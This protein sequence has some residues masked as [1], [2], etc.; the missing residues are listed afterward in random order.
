MKGTDLKAL[1]DRLRLARK[2][3]GFEEAKDA[4]ASLGVNRFTYA[5]HENGTRG[6]K[7]DKAELYARRF[8]VNIE[9]LLTGKGL[10]RPRGRAT[11]LV[12]LVGYV[13]AGAL[14]HIFA[15]GQGNLDMVEAPDGSTPETVAVEIRGESLGSFFD[16]WLVFYD[17]VRAPLT[18][19]MIGKL[20]VLGLADGRIL[21]KKLRKGQIA[22]HWTL[23][24]QF[25]PPIYDALVEWGAIVKSMVPR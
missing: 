8:G 18:P 3:A 23:E 19:Y 13:G 25:E 7:R 5:Q 11:K 22:G 15:E 16:Q 24:S 20:C 10:M 14:A 2:E 9:W 12:P 21:I 4:A 6:F 17:D 1:G